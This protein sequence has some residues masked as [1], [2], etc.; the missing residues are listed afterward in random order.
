ME[1]STAIACAVTAFLV[2]A[3]LSASFLGGCAVSLW[4]AREYK[5]DASEAVAAAE[6]KAY[7][8]H[9]RELQ[10][11]LEVKKSVENSEIPLNPQEAQDNFE[12]GLARLYPDV[13][14]LQEVARKRR[15]QEKMLG[16]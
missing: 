12:E 11:T 1:W 15:E 14:A 16:R 2:I 9:M 4:L 8:D 13:P 6:A 5:R 10:R 7:A 3:G